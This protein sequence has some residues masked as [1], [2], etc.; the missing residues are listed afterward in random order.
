MEVLGAQAYEVVL[1]MRIWQI[2]AVAMGKA[3]GLMQV[4]LKTR[5]RSPSLSWAACSRTRR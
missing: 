1:P 5:N 2:Q 3:A 4:N